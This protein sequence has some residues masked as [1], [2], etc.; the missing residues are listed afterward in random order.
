[1]QNTGAAFHGL[2]R[3]TLGM[4]MN[5][6]FARKTFKLVILITASTIFATVLTGCKFVKN[7]QA[8]STEIARKNKGADL[9]Q[10]VEDTYSSKLLPLISDKALRVAALRVAIAA[11]ITAAGEAHGNRGAGLG[12][13]WNFAAKGEGTVIAAKLESSARK[14]QIDTDGDGKADLTLQLG[15][16]IKGTVLRDYAPFYNFGDF[17]DQIEFAKLGRKLNDRVK[18]EI[19][20]EGTSAELIGKKVTFTGV[21][22][23]KKSN[24]AWLLTVVDIK[25]Q[26]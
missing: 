1:M 17:R 18:K 24:D 2:R 3:D 21:F 9:A 25:V 5:T 10:I 19:K 22:A 8:G 13:A 12:S 23:L 20:I 4:H 6:L 26:P 14:V 7:D 11:D 15:P 16:I